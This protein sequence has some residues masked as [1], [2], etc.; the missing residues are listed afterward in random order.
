VIYQPQLKICGV[1]NCEDAQLVSASGA[2]Y[3]GIL[4][5]V[6]FSERSLS[7]RVA[8]EV[9]LASKIP[10]VILLC[11]PKAEEVETVVQA[12]K[13]YAI[14]L[15]CREPPD[16]VKKLKNRVHC[17]IWKTIHL[18]LT[19]GQASPEDYVEAGVDALLVDSSDTSEGFLRLGGT[20]KVAD[21]KAAANIVTKI[22]IPVFLAG[23]ISPENIASA[24]QEVH[25]FGVDLCS[26]VEAFKGKKDPQ[27]I[28]T[29]IDNFNAATK[30]LEK[31]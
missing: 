8:R 12:I 21:W 7:L 28:R 13:P 3:C 14:Q 10:V 9:A 22:P 1:T 27:K 6:S 29:L 31:G 17:L 25:P 24:L 26:G 15:L 16:L 23:G 2:N 18:P 5:E 20:G 19:L 11:D 30:R 4:V